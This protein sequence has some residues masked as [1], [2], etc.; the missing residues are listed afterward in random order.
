[1]QPQNGLCYTARQSLIGN[2]WTCSL[3]NELV[4][5]AITHA[6]VAVGSLTTRVMLYRHVIAAVRD[7]LLSSIA[8]VVV[9]TN[10]VQQKW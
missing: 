7:K 3:S 5:Q 2:I 9:A 8:E 4:A 1:M 6:S 10:A